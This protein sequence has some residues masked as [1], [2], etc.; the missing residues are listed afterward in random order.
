MEF[1]FF[2]HAVDILFVLFNFFFFMKPVAIH[3][4]FYFK[5]I[6]RGHFVSK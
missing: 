5:I 3:R 1:G 6:K 4:Y 2:A